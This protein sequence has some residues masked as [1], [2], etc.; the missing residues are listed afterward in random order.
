MWRATRRKLKQSEAINS[1]LKK[2]LAAKEEVLK[3]VNEKL[4][5]QLTVIDGLTQTV[6][7]LNRMLQLVSTCKIQ[8]VTTLSSQKY[9][10]LSLELK[11]YQIL[12]SCR[13]VLPTIQDLVGKYS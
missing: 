2:Q 7:S 12:G 13:L 6:E 11:F 10:Q 9:F 4:E 5:Q 3:S 8:F 1:H